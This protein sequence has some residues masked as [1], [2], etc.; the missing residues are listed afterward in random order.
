MDYYEY[1]TISKHDID[2]RY[3]ELILILL[4]RKGVNIKVLDEYK[5]T[6]SSLVNS[7]IINIIY[8]I[9]ITMNHLQKKTTK[10]TRNNSIIINNNNNII[11][12]TIITII[13][14]Y[15]NKKRS[16]FCVIL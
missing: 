3:N 1:I 10:P 16:L 5:N 9:F 15:T 2:H 11:I 6:S 14:Q 8:R 4:V 7:I 12:I 13:N